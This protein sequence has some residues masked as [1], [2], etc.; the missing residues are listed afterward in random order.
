MPTETL[1]F[2]EP[3]FAILTELEALEALP[4]TDARNRE[5]EALQRKL[6]T[7]RATLYR[8][9]TP[10]QRVMV[11]RDQADLL[12]DQ[13]RRAQPAGRHQSQQLGEVGVRHASKPWRR[14]PPW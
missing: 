13:V 3:I 14:P 4:R 7:V 8:D 9:L 11:A 10:W 1:D 5:I 12:G 2:E 6:E